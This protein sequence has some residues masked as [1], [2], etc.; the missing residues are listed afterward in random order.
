MAIIAQE[1]MSYYEM[2]NNIILERHLG[3]DRG[4]KDQY[5]QIYTSFFLKKA[6]DKTN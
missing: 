2:V 6:V 5:V 1:E 3:I 4:R